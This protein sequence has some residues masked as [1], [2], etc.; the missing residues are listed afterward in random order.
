MKT[1][2]VKRNDIYGFDAEYAGFLKKV[3]GCIAGEAGKLCIGKGI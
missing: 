2:C 3:I 1:G